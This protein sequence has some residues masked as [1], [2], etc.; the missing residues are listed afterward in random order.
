VYFL[1][2]SGREFDAF[3]FH[4]PRSSSGTTLLRVLYHRRLLAV[5][6]F[7]C[8]YGPVA[9]H[10]S[11][12]KVIPHLMA[13]YSLTASS[14][15]AGT[16]LVPR[17]AAY[18]QFLTDSNEQYAILNIHSTWE[19]SSVKKGSKKG[20][21]MKRSAHLQN[22]IYSFNQASVTINIFAVRVHPR[23]PYVKWTSRV[24]TTT[25]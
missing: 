9:F 24:Q 13:V 17:Y 19:N 18:F 6:V 7:A 4:F 8:K 11:P 1:C 25:F 15:T 3:I 20:T 21:K 10:Q 14:S 2:G 16:R 22:T 23:R 5:I 12:P